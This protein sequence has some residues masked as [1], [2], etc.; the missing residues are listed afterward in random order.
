MGSFE[1]TLHDLGSN[2]LATVSIPDT[3]AHSRVIF[4]LQEP[5]RG[6]SEL[7]WKLRVLL[8]ERGAERRFH[9]QTIKTRAYFLTNEVDVSANM[10]S[11]RPRQ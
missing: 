2:V 5:R 8:T 3:N 11:S 1:F 4:D 10:E 7:V 9:L 6:L